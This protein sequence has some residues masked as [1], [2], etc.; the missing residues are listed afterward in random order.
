MLHA[1]VQSGTLSRHCW[2][3]GSLIEMYEQYC[4]DAEE[5]HFPKRCRVLI[6]HLAHKMKIKHLK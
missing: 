5:N 4:Q 1:P 6:M 2:I 3:F